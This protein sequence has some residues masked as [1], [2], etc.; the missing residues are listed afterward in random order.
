MANL[1]ADYNRAVLEEELDLITQRIEDMKKLLTFIPVNAPV[2]DPKIGM[3]MYADGE[4]NNFDGHRGRGLYRYD[5]L[6]K[7][8][9]NDLGWIR[10]ASA[11]TEPYVLTGSAGET[12]VHDFLSDFILVKYTGGNGTWTLDLPDPSVQKYRTIRVVS[13]DSTSANHKVA[14]NPGAFTI[15]GSTADYEINRNFEGVTLF[16]DGANWIIIQ[17]KDK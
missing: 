13:D 6:N 12:H 1:P 4:E 3:I 9:D 2:T 10:F 16:S 5:Y 14:L 17:A 7:D 11:D 15:D 8:V